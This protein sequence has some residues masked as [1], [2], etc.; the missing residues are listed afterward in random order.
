M[1]GVTYGS[2]RAGVLGPAHISMFPIAILAITVESF[3]TKVEQL[4]V[5]EALTILLQSVVVIVSAYAA[6]SSF[7]LQTVIFGFPE[8]LL[9][10][11]AA[12][13]ALGR[14]VGLRL[15]EYG[16]FRWLWVG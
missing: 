8:T 2:V 5:R 3:A 6:M 12:Y 7:L 4:G 9:A 14:Y 13:L 10:V 16:R 1:L 11:G 15:A